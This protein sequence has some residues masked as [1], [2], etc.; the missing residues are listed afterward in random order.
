MILTLFCSIFSQGSAK[1]FVSPQ[2]PY[3]GRRWTDDP[4]VP[5]GREP[6]RL[7]KRVKKHGFPS[8]LQL[9]RAEGGC[10]WQ[11]AALSPKLGMLLRAESTKPSSRSRLVTAQHSHCSD[12]H[13]LHSLGE[14]EVQG[15]SEAMTE[16]MW[17]LLTATMR[18]WGLCS[19]LHFFALFLLVC[20]APSLYC[21]VSREE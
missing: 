13:P 12:L 6:H 2:L 19:C 16:M 18:F 20:D 11:V 17:T 10:Q 21:S 14:N 1:S 4:A 3:S 8:F 5:D 7:V 9:R 15:S